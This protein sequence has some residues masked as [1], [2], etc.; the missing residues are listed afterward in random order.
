MEILL[1]VLVML[2][3]A[4]LFRVPFFPIKG[5][6]QQPEND[7]GAQKYYDYQP[8]K[9][10]CTKNE[11]AFYQAL[12]VVAHG[13]HTVFSKVRIADVMAPRKGIYNKSS[14]WRAFNAIAK[15]HVD[16]VL[17]DPLTLEVKL[18]V[19]LDDSTHERQD[20]KDR[21]KLVDMAAASAGIQ[22]K[23][24]KVQSKYDYFELE[25]EL[26]DI[27]EEVDVPEGVYAER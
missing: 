26:Y 7:N 2:L 13:K 18:L 19:E 6:Q 8:I 9:H 12:L 22:I 16:F 11:L 3:L 17:C 10:L 20:R 14:W 21:D 27:E 5:Q 15:K 1:I 4:T 23:H 25:K 24:I